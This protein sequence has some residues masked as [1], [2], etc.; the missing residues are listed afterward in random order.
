MTTQPD[1][2]APAHDAG[3]DGL[4]WWRRG[5]AQGAGYFLPS[6]AFVLV[7]F[8]FSEGWTPRTWALAILAAV[9]LLVFFLGTTVVLHWSETRRWLWFAGLLGAIAV[10]GWVTDGDA[11]PAYFAAFATASAAVLIAW[12]HARIVIPALS[13]L[14]LGWSLVRGDAFGVV[15]GMM[16][17]GIGWGI[18]SSID[19]E[20]TKVALRRAEQ[21]TAVLAVAA[22][23]ERIG[24]DLHDILG[25]SLTTI[26]V[27]ADLAQRLVGRSDDAARAEIASLADVARQA[28]A[29][30]RATASGMREVRLAAEVAAARSV[31]DAAGI[32]CRTPSALPVLDDARSEL[33][34]Y[35]VR[36]AVTNVVRHA[37]ASVCRITVDDAA[38]TITDDGRGFDTRSGRTGLRGLAERLDAA[39][40]RLDV[41]SSDAGTTVHAALEP[42]EEP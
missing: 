18:G 4:P 12:R 24:R 27:K 22:E 17:F 5:L 7:P 25:H 29:D 35:V 19:A 14:A 36:E 1:L 30:V 26:A 2:S 39:G 11:R 31:L 37:G 9:A 34:G 20:R 13:L 16:A 32:E 15:M 8:L 33:F 28:L 40:G 6:G 10:L 41:T 23:R 38:I 3:A 42:R 21:R